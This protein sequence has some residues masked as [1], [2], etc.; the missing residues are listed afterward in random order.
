MTQKFDP[1][2]SFNALSASPTQYG[3]RAMGNM[4][5]VRKEKKDMTSFVFSGLLEIVS[6]GSATFLTN[7]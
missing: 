2:T 3:K 5:L 4:S 6:Q 1:K 7:T